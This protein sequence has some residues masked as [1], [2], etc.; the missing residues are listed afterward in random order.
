MS[1]LIVCHNYNS[2]ECIL[3]KGKTVVCQYD[4]VNDQREELKS[5]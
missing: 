2:I 3:T 5:L 1:F 4:A